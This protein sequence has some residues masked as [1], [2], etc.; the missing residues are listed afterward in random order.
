[1][2]RRQVGDRYEERAAVFLEGQGYRIVERNYRYARGE[3]DIIGWDGRYLA[4]IEVKYRR[5]GARGGALEAVGIQK[6]RRICR[7][8]LHYRMQR[9]IPAETPCRFDVVGIEAEEMILVKN[10]FD[11][12]YGKPW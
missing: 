12:C 8:A 9:R 3:I 7:T 6:Q 11:L 5:D 4:F 10:A 1:M 2:D